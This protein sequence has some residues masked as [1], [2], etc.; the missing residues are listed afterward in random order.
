MLSQRVVLVFL[1][2]VHGRVRPIGGNEC[3]GW[4]PR[5][6][7]PT[8]RAP[9]IPWARQKYVERVGCSRAYVVGIG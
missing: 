4:D 7:P 5:E 1:F 3:R 9:R 8:Q 2:T 6:S